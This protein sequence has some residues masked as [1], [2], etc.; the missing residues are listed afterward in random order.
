M[1]AKGRPLGLMVAWLAYG[2]CDACTDKTQ[3][4]DKDAMALHV[5]HAQRTAARDILAATAAGQDLLSR[6]RPK[7][8]SETDE[9]EG[10][11]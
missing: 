10:L 1:K 5:T 9:P 8:A 7:R 2:Q 11:A 4:W 6:E 3:H